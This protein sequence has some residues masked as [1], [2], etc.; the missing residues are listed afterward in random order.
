M[1]SAVA[2]FRI[3]QSWLGHCNRV[4]RVASR[5]AGH[6]ERGY[7]VRLIGAER[8]S[9]RGVLSRPWVAVTV[10]YLEEFRIYAALRGGGTW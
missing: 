8:S 2:H 1:W 7:M 9:V 4:Q 6:K 5:K 10:F 3:D